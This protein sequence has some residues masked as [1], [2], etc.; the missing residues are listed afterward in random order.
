MMRN[1]P[2]D[3]LGLIGKTPI[4]NLKK[5]VPS[6]S[7]CVLLKLE[8][9]NPSG[10]IKDRI[11]LGLIED[12]EARDKI[13]SG[14]HIIY[15]T[16]GNIGSALAMVTAAKG[17]KLTIFMPGN[18]PIHQ[19]KIIQGYGANI[20]LTSPNQG[21]EGSFSGARTMSESIEDSL[22]LDFFGN[23]EAVNIHYQTTASEIT[24]AI[25]GQIDAFVAGVGTGATLMGIGQ[26]LK[27]INPLV[28]IIAVEPAAS[29]IISGGNPGQHGIPGIGPNFLPPLLDLNSIDSVIQVTEQQ[30]RTMTT[31][32]TKEEG[33]LVGVSSGANVF[34]AIK[35]GL[36]LGINGRVL[37]IAPDRGDHY[38]D[39]AIQ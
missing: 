11:A 34:A 36:A 30:A 9:Q 13:Q 12:A 2:I 7:A 37:T 28:K 8:G 17:Y 27:E 21:M 1:S 35:T 38:L 16:S 5:V 25:R 10:S 23:K 19:R 3:I 15:A 32:L 26:K 4:L 22:L 39:F 29:P 6:E 24:N 18:S 14:G 31:K 20:K 33:L